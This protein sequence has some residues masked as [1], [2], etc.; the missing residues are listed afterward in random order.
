MQTRNHSIAGLALAAFAAVIFAWEPFISGADAGERKGGGGNFGVIVEKDLFRP[1]RKKPEPPQPRPGPKPSEH[2][3]QAPAIILSG[4]VILDNGAVAMLSWQGVTSGSGAYMVGD[5]IEEF[6]IVDITRDMVV[7]R[8][9]DEVLSARM[10]PGRL[11][12][13]GLKP[14]TRGQ[15]R[16]V[17]EIS[18]ASPR[19]GFS[20]EEVPVTGKGAVDE[21]GVDGGKGWN[22]E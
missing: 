9:G 4:T 14:F 20:Y 1:S 12:A 22:V 5:H 16:A 11:P 17:K 13:P 2:K 8:R 10:S 21:T 7:L 15:V 18:P 3:R 6:V 19:E